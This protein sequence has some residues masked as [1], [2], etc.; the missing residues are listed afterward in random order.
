[1][2]RKKER[3]TGRQGE[4]EIER[5]RETERYKEREGGRQT[6]RRKMIGGRQEQGMRGRQTG[7]DKVFFMLE[8]RS[9]AMA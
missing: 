9:Y 1:M 5:E 2:G 6:E 8:H 4:N 7:T 3:Q